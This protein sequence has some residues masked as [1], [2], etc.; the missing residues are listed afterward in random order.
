MCRSSRPAVRWFAA[1]LTAVSLPMTPAFA[2]EKV[3]VSPAYTYVTPSGEAFFGVAVRAEDLSAAHRPAARHVLLIDTS[4]SQAGEYRQRELIAAK[5][6]LAALPA[7]AKV[8]ILA[9]DVT[10]EPLTDGFVSPQEALTQGLAALD[11]RVPLGATDLALGLD[12]ALSAFEQ[13]SAGSIIYIGDGMSAA[14]LLKTGELKSL[15]ASLRNRHVPVH[16]LAVGPDTDWHLLGVLA[17]HTGGVVEL[18]ARDADVAELGQRLAAAAAAP[19]VYPQALKA[20]GTGTLILGDAVP[21]LRTDR[22]T[23]LLG[24]GE[25][26]ANISVTVDG[27]TSP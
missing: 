19:V 24:R 7:S 26:P 20:S 10:A 13:G 14:N 3:S 25:R 16:A 9:V 1:G 17:H 22:E 23:I 11:K 18:D 21:P 8:S 27:R 6:L 5:S 12:A 4:A 15:T 2:A